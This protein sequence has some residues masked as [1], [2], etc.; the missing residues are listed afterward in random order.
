MRHTPHGRSPSYTCKA[1]GCTRVTRTLAAVDELVTRVVCDWLA[2]PEAA[3]AFASPTVDKKRLIAEANALRELVIAAERE[4]D[5]GIIDG[6]RLAARKAS[7]TEKL[8]P[9]EAALLG[10]ICPAPSTGW[11]ASQSP[12]AFRGAVARPATRRD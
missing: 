1:D 7:M 8:Q 6:R 9:I 10:A 11:P 4:Y 12:R 5:D 3:E 2:Q